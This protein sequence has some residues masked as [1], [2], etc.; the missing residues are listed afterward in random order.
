MKR[1]AWNL[2]LVRR[3]TWTSPLENM[4]CKWLNLPKC[5]INDH[6]P[7]V[8]L[9]TGPSQQEQPWRT[10]Q[11]EAQGRGQGHRT[12]RG[13]PQPKP[14]R[15]QNVHLLQTANNKHPVEY[16]TDD[17]EEQCYSLETR[18]SRSILILSQHSMSYTCYQC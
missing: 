8:S 3:P 13:R 9:K 14:P 1:E 18:I 11:W 10:T 15:E 6:F 4:P 2:L 16:C 12:P 7:R 17:Y 5:G